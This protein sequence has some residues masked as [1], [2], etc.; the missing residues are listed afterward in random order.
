MLPPK[1]DHYLIGI[2]ASA[3]GLE[4][5]HKLFDHFPNNSTFS[6]VIIQHLSPDHKSLMAELL[7]K[8]TQM[9][10]QEAEDDMITRP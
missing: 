9:R 10:V 8:H 2:G 6:F 5:I 4:A 7:S 3:G 1:T